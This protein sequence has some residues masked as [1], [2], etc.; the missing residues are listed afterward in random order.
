MTSCNK[1][2]SLETKELEKMKSQELK[3]LCKHYGVKST[4]IK[5]KLI[6]RINLAQFIE[7]K[8]NKNFQEK[9]IPK[10]LIMKSTDNNLFSSVETFQKF[11]SL[12]SKK[13]SQEIIGKIDNSKNNNKILNLTKD[14]IDFCKS[15]NLKFSIPI[16]LDGEHM[17]HRTRTTIDDEDEEEEDDEEFINE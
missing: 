13:N 4:G 2:K 12:V 7:N 17:T 9:S 1:I 10:I 8:V 14:D 6:Q 5:N 16:I 15:K 3:D 11:Y